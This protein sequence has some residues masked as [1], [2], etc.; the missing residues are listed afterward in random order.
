MAVD[1]KP[2]L[3]GHDPKAKIG[4]ITAATIE[5]NAILIEG[6]IYA[7]DFPEVAAEIEDMSKKL[8]EMVKP[9]ADGL[10]ALETKLA[11]VKAAA[12]ADAK[13]PERKT[14]PASITTLAKAGLEAPADGSKFSLATV[15]KALKELPVATRLQ[16]KAGLTQNGLLD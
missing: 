16:V 2:A 9:L 10:K 12:V 1:Y 14:L 5:G 3:D 15:D 4:V 6:F 8:D 7:A 13:A 11:D